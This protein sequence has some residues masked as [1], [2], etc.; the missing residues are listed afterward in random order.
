MSDSGGGS[1]NTVTQ[2]QQIPDFEQQSSI[3]NQALA[4]SIGTQP[5]PTYQS[6]LIQGFSP[7]QQAGQSAA[8]GAAQSYSPYLDAATQLT[9]NALDPTSVNNYSGAAAGQINSALNP[10]GVNQY[11]NYATNMLGAQ[12]GATNSARALS[13]PRSVGQFMNPYIEQALAPQMQDLQLQ[14]AQQ[15]RGIDQQATQANAFGDAR[16]GAAQSLQNLYGNQAMNQL[17]GTGYNN[18]YSQ[19]LQALQGQQGIQLGAAGQYGNAAGQYGNLAGLQGQ[20]QQYQLTG[21]G[22]FAN[23]AGIQGQEQQTQLTGANQIAG[24]G[25]QAQGLG[26]TGANAIYNAGQQQQQLG[27]Q[28][29]N[30]AYQQYL[31]QINWPLQMLNVQESALSNSPY[32]LSSATTLPQANSVAQGF[33]GLSSIA[34][35]LGAL[36]GG[37]GGGANSP[38]GGTQMQSP[39]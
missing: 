4:Q 28:E 39:K 9:G 2:V 18:A 34:G 1:S 23:L 31:N 14:L 33:G 30:T 19:A 10:S 27:Q 7:L 26:I 8:V 32:N 16:Q 25:G 13:D 37:G 6:Q 36:G 24:L 5:Y 12:A 17:V 15:Q 29:L 35:L 22:Q 20:Q 3:N 38:F 11:S 21:A